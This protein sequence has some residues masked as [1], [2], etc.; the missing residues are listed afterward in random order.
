MNLL[1]SNNQNIISFGIIENCADNVCLD[2]VLVARDG[3]VRVNFAVLQIFNTWL[4]DLWHSGET[5]LLLP[6]YTVAEVY[7]SLWYQMW[8]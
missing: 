3:E 8:Y 2:T 7:K 6:D 4:R 5:V 1:L